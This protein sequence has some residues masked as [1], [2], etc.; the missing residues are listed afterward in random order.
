MSFTGK[1]QLTLTEE[2]N[3]LSGKVFNILGCNV[4]N[5]D[6]KEAEAINKT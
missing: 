3:I 2:K 5:G 6:I 1:Y 4:C